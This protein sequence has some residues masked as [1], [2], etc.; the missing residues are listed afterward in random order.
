[1]PARLSA[2]CLAL[3]LAAPLVPG[4]T[5]DKA[6]ATAPPAAPA[7]VARPPA[8]DFPE[9]F[10]GGSGRAAVLKAV[11]VLIAL[12]FGTPVP[13]DTSQVVVCFEINSYGSVREAQI[14][15]GLSP[16]VDNAVLAAVRLLD[17]HKPGDYVHSPKSHILSIAAIGSASPAQRRETTTRWQRTARRL[18]GEADTTFVRRVLPLSYSSTRA[19]GLQALNWRPGP[20]G[21]QLVFTQSV[22]DPDG[23]LTGWHNTDLFVL[24]PFGP[25]TYA[26]QQFHLYDWGDVS[27]Q[28]VAPFV[29]DVNGDG[30][31]DLVTLITYTRSE[32]W[33]A[34]DGNT[35]SGHF[36]Y[37]R[38]QVWRTAGLDKAGRP[39]YREDKTPYPYLEYRQDETPG[40][41]PQEFTP[42]TVR[43][44]LARHQRQLRQ[45]RRLAAVAPPPD[46]AATDTTKKA[47]AASPQ[48]G[49]PGQ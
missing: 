13:A 7:T 18:P 44:L 1:M 49:D 21:P 34:D 22:L 45:G 30:S 39:R 6:P 38:V 3:L 27:G 8:E 5:P 42:A 28:S 14:V 33:K 17:F 4:C 35:Y 16:A 24:D 40:P 11:Q 15:R 43:R 31:P 37:Y 36:D 48:E 9:L 10:D 19:G 2:V 29:A 26:V 32:D 47:G 25:R 20:Y 12:P 23:P 41:Y 46:S